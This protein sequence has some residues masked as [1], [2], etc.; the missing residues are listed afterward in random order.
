MCP[1]NAACAELDGRLGHDWS[2]DRRHDR[3]RDLV[4]TGRG[5]Q[6]IRLGYDDVVA[7]PCETAALVTRVL[8]SRGWRV[9]PACCGPACRLGTFLEILGSA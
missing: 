7:R 4:L 5:D 6:A 8:W 1:G 9:R 2:T 3:M